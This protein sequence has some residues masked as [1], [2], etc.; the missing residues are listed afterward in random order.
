[1][2]RALLYWIRTLLGFPIFVQ[3]LYKN[4]KKSRAKKLSDD[5]MLIPTVGDM[6]AYGNPDGTMM[7][8][9][10]Y[11]KKWEPRLTIFDRL[12]ETLS[13]GNLFRFLLAKSKYNQLKV[14]E[15]E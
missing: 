10:H 12:V 5:R 6:R 4:V 11:V 2:L 8:S 13:V 15:E 3:D 9:H 7:E 14:D 1:M